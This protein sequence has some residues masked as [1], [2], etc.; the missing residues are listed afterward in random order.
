[1]NTKDIVIFTDGSSSG[2][3]GPGGW[4]AIIALANG[5]VMEQGG[6]VEYTTNNRM[7]LQAAIE[8]LK[9]IK[10]EQGNVVINTDSS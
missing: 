4:A 3:P 1:M 9:I 5:T 8:S 10:D 7:E 6:R 2:N